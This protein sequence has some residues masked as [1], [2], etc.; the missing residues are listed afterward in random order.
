MSSAPLLV[1][2]RTVELDSCSDQLPIATIDVVHLEDEL[3]TD[4]TDLLLF[5]LF[6]SEMD[7]ASAADTDV[8][9]LLHEQIKA[10]RVC[11]ELPRSREVAHPDEE[12]TQSN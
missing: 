10:E 12:M 6:D 8:A 3:Y 11:V 5:P 7:A 9:G 4:G 1:L 2:G